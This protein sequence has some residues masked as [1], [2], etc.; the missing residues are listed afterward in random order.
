MAAKRTPPALCTSCQRIDFSRFVLSA[1]N[2]RYSLDSLDSSGR[3]YEDDKVDEEE[4]IEAYLQIE[5]S[6][7]LYHAHI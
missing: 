4:S 1:E 6:G 5:V 3:H 2:R 7:S